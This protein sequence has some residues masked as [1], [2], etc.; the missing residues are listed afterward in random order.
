MIDRRTW[1]WIAVAATVLLAIAA[2]F[3]RRQTTFEEAEVLARRYAASAA[4]TCSQ[5][6]LGGRFKIGKPD[7]TAMAGGWIFDFP[8]GRG[9]V[10]VVVFETRRAQ[11]VGVDCGE[12]I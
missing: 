6:R 4:N 7:Y 8:I 2:V 11:Y 3:S 9:H 10:G 5:D 1:L 12:R